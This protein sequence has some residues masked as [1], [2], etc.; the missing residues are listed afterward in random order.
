ML[1]SLKMLIGAVAL[2][3][4]GAAA[5]GEPGVRP[6]PVFASWYQVRAEQRVIEFFRQ[7]VGAT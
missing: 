2:V 3:L 6:D 1:R 7:R 4:A 5:T